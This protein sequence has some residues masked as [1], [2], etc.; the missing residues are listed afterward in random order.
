[1][2]NCSVEEYAARAKQA[3]A[4]FDYDDEYDEDSVLSAVIHGET[5]LAV[6]EDE[7][8]YKGVQRH[9]VIGVEDAGAGKAHQAEF[10]SRVADAQKRMAEFAQSGWASFRWDLVTEGVYIKQARYPR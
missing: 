3:A 10:Y 6:D 4:A 7:P 2:P 9:L 8:Y 5:L 1:M